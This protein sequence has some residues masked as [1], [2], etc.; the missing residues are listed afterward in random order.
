M[1]RRAQYWSSCFTIG[2]LFSVWGLRIALIAS[3]ASRIIVQLYV[4]ERHDMISPQDCTPPGLHARAGSAH[5]RAAGSA[6]VRAGSAHVRAG[7]AHV[8][9]GSAQCTWAECYAGWAI[10]V[11]DIRCTRGTWVRAQR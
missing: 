10:A 1:E 7:S 8:R 3:R 5:V 4:K 11:R 9:A 6:H 2:A